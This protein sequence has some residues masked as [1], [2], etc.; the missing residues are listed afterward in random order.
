MRNG[1]VH[2]VQALPG[3]E[4]NMKHGIVRSGRTTTYYGDDANNMMARISASHTYTQEEAEKKV[5]SAGGKYRTALIAELEHIRFKFDHEPFK[6]KLAEQVAEEKVRAKQRHR[7]ARLA[8]LRRGVTRIAKMPLKIPCGYCKTP[9]LKDQAYWRYSRQ[10]AHL[11]CAAAEGREL[12]RP[13]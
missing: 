10:R 7:E 11:K 3:E 4:S 12:G 1:A 5:L 6:T 8:D 2:R 9:I 13:E